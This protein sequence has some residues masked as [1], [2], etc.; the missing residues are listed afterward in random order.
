MVAHEKEL[1][2]EDQLQYLS[3]L[4]YS[5]MCCMRKAGL[6]FDCTYASYFPSSCSLRKCKKYHTLEMSCLLK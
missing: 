3:L 5:L 4:D 2:S 6:D 1:C